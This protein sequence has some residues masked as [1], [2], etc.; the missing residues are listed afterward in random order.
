MFKRLP[1]YGLIAVFAAFE[2]AVLWLALHPDVPEDYRAYYIDQSTTCLN[3]P[4]TGEYR[5][6][7]VIDFTASEG[8]LSKPFKA[9]GWK[10][11]SKE[12][13]D[14]VGE[15]SRLR[16]IFPQ[17]APSLTLQFEAIAVD[18]P[19]TPTQTVKVL[20][21]GVP[22]GEVTIDQSAPQNFKLAI[23]A[24][25][26]AAMPGRIELRFDYPEAFAPPGI[27]NT[28]KRSIKLLW[29]TLQPNPA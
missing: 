26:I 18:H 15:T 11:P 8:D 28:Y 5:L 25:A 9:C 27:A 2:I 16:F 13:T 10:G 3:Q 21:N 12:G 23:P 4:V 22:V 20:A 24:E 29:I 1:A 17:T 6:G 7:Q 14:A 19:E